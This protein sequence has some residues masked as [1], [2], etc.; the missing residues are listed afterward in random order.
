MI[1]TWNLEA[2]GTHLCP[3]SSTACM[4]KYLA[5]TTNSDS[6]PGPQ[7]TLFSGLNVPSAKSRMLK[8]V[9]SPMLG[10]IFC[11][12]KGCFR[13]IHQP[14]AWDV[15]T[16]D[17]RQLPFTWPTFL[18][19]PAPCVLLWN[20]HAPCWHR[21]CMTLTDWRDLLHSTLVWKKLFLA[22]GTWTS[23]H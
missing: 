23:L 8:S 19:R 13:G 14:S 12:P 10:Y 2:G 5:G 7:I 16:C 4:K 6:K 11:C 20:W 22:L 9:N 21:R 18:S 17:K 15:S 1:L 3:C